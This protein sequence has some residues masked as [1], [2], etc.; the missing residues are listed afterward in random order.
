MMVCCKQL[1]CGYAT[2]TEPSLLTCD[3]CR[4]LTFS[5]WLDTYEGGLPDIYCRGSAVVT[6]NFYGIHTRIRS[7]GT[8]Y[9]CASIHIFSICH[10]CCLPDVW[11]AH[12][13]IL[14]RFIV[15]E[16]H[17]R[18]T[19]GDCAP[20]GSKDLLSPNQHTSLGVLV[21]SGKSSVSSEPDRQSL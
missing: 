19:C 13:R 14:L 5:G 4:S 15:P 17:H 6:C 8:S 2:L 9:K 1:S 10:H 21:V 11:R 7:A 3:E 16:A 18:N 20:D 12:D